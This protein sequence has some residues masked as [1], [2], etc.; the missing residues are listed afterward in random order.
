MIMIF[1]QKYS[2]KNIPAKIFQQALISVGSNIIYV[3]A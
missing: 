3:K 2:G 1:Q